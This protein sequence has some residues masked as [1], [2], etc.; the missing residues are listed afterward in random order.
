MLCPAQ[1]PQ[2][3]RPA[4]LAAIEAGRIRSMQNKL[5]PAAPLHRAGALLLGDAFN[6]RHPLTGKFLSL[7]HR[8]PS[9]VSL[10]KR[11]TSRG[12]CCWGT[13]LEHAP[14]ADRFMLTT[15]L[16]FCCLDG[17]PY[18]RA[19]QSCFTL[20]SYLKNTLLATAAIT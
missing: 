1:V 9:A 18:R 4:F 12:R 3:L 17:R 10:S 15:E 5:M 16:S 13:P 20:H 6:M 14:P 8:N 7:S 19:G 2:Q 11:C